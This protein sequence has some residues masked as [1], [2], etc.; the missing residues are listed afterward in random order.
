[1]RSDPIKITRNSTVK[2]EPF[3]TA[4]TLHL[5][6]DESRLL[7]SLARI[8]EYPTGDWFDSVEQCKELLPLSDHGEAKYFSDFCIETQTV[9]LMKLQELYTRTF[10]LNP[11]CALEVGYHLFGEDYKRGAFLAQL[12]ETESPY[13]LGQ[14][15]QLPDYLPVCLRLLSSMEDAEERAALIGCCLIPALDIMNETFE[16]KQSPYG[17]VIKFLT[18]TLKRLAEK[19]VKEAAGKEE[20]RYRYA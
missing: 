13:Q 9:P 15:H 10:D 1:M 4:E 11:V 12:S 20:T 17:N 19:S 2:I 8:L 14:E 3:E 6:E 5:L 18:E 7:N 16:K